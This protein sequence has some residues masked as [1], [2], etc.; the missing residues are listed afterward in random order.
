MGRQGRRGQ[1]LHSAGGHGQLRESP[2]GM[3]ER[4]LK[5]GLDRVVLE[6]CL[7]PMLMPA[8]GRG[9]DWAAC[10]ADEGEARGHLGGLAVV[11]QSKPRALHVAS[12]A[13]SAAH[14]YLPQPVGPVHPARRRGRVLCPGLD[15]GLGL[16]LCLGLGLVHTTGEPHRMTRRDDGQLHVHQAMR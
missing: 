5:H 1:A 12:R 9:R 8:T 11:F 15:L 13:S 14:R 16:G 4:E 3:A 2:G 6:V 10:K 7:D